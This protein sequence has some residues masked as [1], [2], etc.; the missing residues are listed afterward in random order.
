MVKHETYVKT[1]LKT[2][3]KPCGQC[4]KSTI[5]K[6][7]CLKCGRIICDNCAKFNMEDRYCPACFEKIKTL[8]KLV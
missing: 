8:Y 1:N 5:A 6:K 2:L 7:S 3:E 4:R